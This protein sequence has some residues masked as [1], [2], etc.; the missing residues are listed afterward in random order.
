M[1]RTRV[2]GFMHLWRG[3]DFGFTLLAS[4]RAVWVCESCLLLLWLL[5]SWKF[6]HEDFSNAWLC[7]WCIRSVCNVVVI[8]FWWTLQEWMKR[9]GMQLHMSLPPTFLVEMPKD[10]TV[11]PW[12][13][14]LKIES[15]YKLLRL[16]G[17]KFDIVVCHEFP[18]H[19]FYFS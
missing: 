8:R 18:V 13:S 5:I 1:W 17:L 7:S 11:N 4:V 19:S 14:S 10:I 9:C 2:L 3:K 6:S 12:G 16:K 15:T